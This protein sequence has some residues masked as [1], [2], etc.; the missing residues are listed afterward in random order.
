MSKSVEKSE[1]WHEA[2]ASILWKILQAKTS[3]SQLFTKTLIETGNKML[4][5]N[6]YTD[7]YWGCGPDLHGL[8]MLGVL[9]Q[10]LR[11][12]LKNKAQMQPTNAMQMKSS[13]VPSQIQESEKKHVTCPK[14]DSPS[15]LILVLGNSNVREM[16]TQ[17]TEL[18]LDTRSFCYPGG[19]LEY[20]TSRIRHTASGPDPTHVV[21]MAEQWWV[22]TL[23]FKGSGGMLHQENF[24]I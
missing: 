10:E 18:N 2:K 22:K 13:V 24:E 3:Q 21:L 4:L 14:T 9:L 8:N 7:T 19:T 20:I 6:I 17:L 16:A 1:E 11:V 15:Y 5:H 23:G 12:Q